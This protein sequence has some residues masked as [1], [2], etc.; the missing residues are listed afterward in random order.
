MGAPALYHHFGSLD[1]FAQAVVARVYDPA[2]FPVHEVTSAVDALARGEVPLEATK[3]FHRNDFTRLRHDPLFRVRLGLWALGGTTVDV[4]YGDLLRG[5]DRRIGASAQSL[6][7]QWGRELRPPV[8]MATYVAAQTAMISG[9]VVRHLVDPAALDAERFA[10]VSSA[11]VIPLLRPRGDARG[12]EDRLTEL[13]GYLRATGGRSATA[14]VTGE[15]PERL[16]KAAE[17]TF[18]RVGYDR[19]TVRQVARAAGVGVST[20]YAHFA[21]LPEL[22]VALVTTR[23][24]ASVAA[25]PPPPR[26][27]APEVDAGV[28]REALMVVAAFCGQRLDYL[29]P[30][31]A[32]VALGP[33]RGDP[34]IG[35]IA[36]HLD[37]DQDVATSVLLVLVGKLV[38]TPGSGIDMAVERALALAHPD[39]SWAGSAEDDTARKDGGS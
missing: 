18:D 15:T 23:F 25:A 20:L 24:T 33:D 11:L 5:I 6:F 3:A 35:F 19:A 30:Y 34:L 36:T 28:A 12:L 1:S 14:G 38:A 27:G 17:K 32:Y 9:S 29:G 4:P 39:N 16:L 21:G 8:D 7:D 13:N 22:A 26:P 2:A 10:Q 37:V 31:A